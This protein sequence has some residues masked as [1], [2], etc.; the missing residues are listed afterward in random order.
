M[1]ILLTNDDGIEAKGLHAIAAKLKDYGDLVVVAPDS[2]RSAISHGITTA[3]P[4]R[5]KKYYRDGQFFGYAFSGTPVDCVKFA[6]FEM[7]KDERP[8]VVVSGI[9]HG[10][11]TG[12]NAMYSGTVAAAA[13]G[14]ILGIPSFAI[15]LGSHDTDK[16]C[17][18]A[19]DYAFEII[20]N[21][22]PRRDAGEYLLSINVP[23]IP[24]ETIRGVKVVKGSNSYWSDKYEKRIDP[25]K[26]PYYWFDGSYIYDANDEDSDD[27]AM[28]NGYVAVTPLQFKFTNVEQIESIRHLE[29]LC[30]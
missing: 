8:D 16:D 30:K 17:S 25:W 13:E 5:V 27:V 26:Q 7:L 4:L 1:K 23:A 19:A 18:G 22:M 3:I 2:Q 20:T 9:N 6:L 14:H 24:P 11:N 10:R 15:S 21:F 29:K 28:D 12:I